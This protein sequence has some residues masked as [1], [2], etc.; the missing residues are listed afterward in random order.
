M[1]KRYPI[2]IIAWVAASSALVPG[3]ASADLSSELASKLSQYCM[4][5]DTEGCGIMR[6]RYQ[7]GACYCGDTAYMWYDAEARRVKCPAGQ[8]PI[9]ASVCPSA[10]YGGKLV[11]D[12]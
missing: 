9:V 7:N 3:T 1:R 2:L 8:I 6:P 10:G 12:F 11:K 5:K 4:P